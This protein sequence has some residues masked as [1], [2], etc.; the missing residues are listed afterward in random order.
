MDTV[1]EGEGGTNQEIRIDIYTLSCIKQIANGKL[2]YSTGS[3]ARCSVM[4]SMGKMGR[5]GWG[6]RESKREG[7]YVYIQLAYFVVQQKPTQHTGTGCQST[8]NG[9]QS[10]PYLHRCIREGADNPV[11]SMH[12]GRCGAI[13]DH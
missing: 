2:L 1:G 6:K 12:S 11:G 4:T 9:E 5:W 3:S 8:Q 13:E 10:D 7:N